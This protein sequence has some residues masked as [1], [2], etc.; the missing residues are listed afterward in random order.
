MI[1][2]RQ[3]RPGDGVV[4]AQRIRESLPPSIDGLT[5]WHCVGVDRWVEM[6]LAAPASTTFY[7]AVDERDRA[8]AAAEF[9]IISDTVFLNQ[10]GVTPSGQGKGIGGRLL[11]TGLRELSQRGGVVSLSLDVETSNERAAAWYRRLGLST[12][13][14]AYWMLTSQQPDG[15]APAPVRGWEEAEREHAR[16][17]FSRFQVDG[18]TGS[19]D[20]GR[21]GASLFRLTSV[22]AWRDLTV[23][24]ALDCIDATRRLLLI[25][26][27]RIGD[28][29]PISDE[30]VVR[31]TER[32]SGPL[33]SI[34]AKLPTP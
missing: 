23:H 32:L 34:L 31:Q 21:L 20:V 33:N 6:H 2:V 27:S 26:G 5:I 7:L 14:R 19:F 4:L 17:G 15:V 12:V 3:A 29:P 8:I 16:Y 30:P 18:S 28:P 22:D 1:T 24:A 13:S 25:S 11:A 9:R 10:I